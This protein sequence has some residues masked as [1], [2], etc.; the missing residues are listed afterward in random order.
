MPE[1][2]RLLGFP[3]AGYFF[4]ASGSYTGFRSKR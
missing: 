2:R 1:G 4:M 3:A